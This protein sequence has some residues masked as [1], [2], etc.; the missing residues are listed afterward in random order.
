M[1]KKNKT[2]KKILQKNEMEKNETSGNITNFQT[3][4][5]IMAKVLERLILD[6]KIA[7]EIQEGQKVRLDVK[8]IEAGSNYSKQSNRYK[9]WVKQNEHEVFAIRYLRT[10][11]K[12]DNS[13]IVSRE[14]IE[15]K[16]DSGN[17][18]DWIFWV[19]YLILV[20]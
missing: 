13:P 16:D 1:S 10:N 8:G 3:S 19:G 12:D 17:I 5:D 14:I 2:N 4:D 7:I 18:C 9:K 11:K 6:K 20:D 15:L